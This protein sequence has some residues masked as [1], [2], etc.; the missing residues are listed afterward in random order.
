M[1][2]RSDDGTS[3][4]RSPWF[5]LVLLV[6]S[7][8]AY[9]TT[10]RTFFQ[11][12]DFEAIDDVVRHGPSLRWLTE[13]GAGSHVRPVLWADLWLTHRLVGLDPLWWHVGNVV[14]HAAV[15]WLVAVLADSL[16]VDDGD[17]P[18]RQ[19]VGPLAGALFV[20][21]PAHAEPVSWIIARVDLIT[22]GL[23]I[24]SL[25]AW[26]R[27]R[28]SD[29]RARWALLSFVGFA[30]A[31]YTKEAVLTFPLVLVSWELWHRPPVPERAA[32][33]RRAAAGLAPQVGLLAVYLW[34][35]TQLD[36]S[37]LGGEG[38]LLGADGPLLVARRWLQ[39]S[40]RSVLPSMPMAAWWVVGAIGAV[41]ALAM[42]W[43]WRRGV[44]GVLRPHGRT[45]GFLVTAHL[46][47]V[48]PVGRLGV[49]PFTTAGE[50]LAYVPSIFATI[51]LALVIGLVARAAPAV[52]R[53]LVPAVIVASVV[54]LVIADATYVR[55]GRLMEGVVASQAHWP[56]DR[57]TVALVAP[58]TLAG[59]WGGRDALGAALV[60]VHGWTPPPAYR[61]VATV[62]LDRPDAR[63]VVVRGSCD[64]CIV[65]RAGAGAR[66]VSPE[67]AGLPRRDRAS[68]LT[69]V[70]ASEREVEVAIDRGADLGA[71]RYLSGGRFVPL[72]R[73]PG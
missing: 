50:R 64:R 65:L 16:L 59:S 22:G 29:E 48:A 36:P 34:H 15:A 45:L 60:L 42:V 66:F 37:F 35:Y 6:A 57:P 10:L 30:L 21:G 31:L 33:W 2:Q 46:V 8:A 61:E 3:A 26:I 18:L 63:I 44:R 12:D 54:L 24:G 14:A 71:Y 67:P 32:S 55:G 9:A 4:V 41:G 7:F 27:W 5:G 28:R 43:G 69:V 68:H 72:R 13:V 19:V 56:R 17:G 1:G 62:A 53:V 52:G 70:R 58:D 11:G 25:L 47:V 20:V 73:L 40:L 23:L 51:G 39:V 38:S 49:S